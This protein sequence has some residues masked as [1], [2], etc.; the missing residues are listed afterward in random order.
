MVATTQQLNER[1]TQ[2]QTSHYPKNIHSH[3]LGFYLIDQN[4]SKS[5]VSATRIWQEPDPGCTLNDLKTST[6]N[7][8]PLQVLFFKI[9]SYIQP[10]GSLCP[11]QAVIEFA[12]LQNP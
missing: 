12:Y 6:A 10:F 2:R 3:P 4:P 7:S 1:D 11:T 5:W 8:R 9:C